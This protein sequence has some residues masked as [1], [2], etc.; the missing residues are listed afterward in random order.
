[1]S[2]NKKEQ[3]ISTSIVVLLGATIMLHSFSLLS[4]KYATL[5]SGLL[6]LGLIAC[7]LCISALRA[8]LW[9]RLLAMRELSYLYP[10]TALVQLVIPFYAVTLFGE[11]VTSG[12]LLGLGFIVAGS[13]TMA[14]D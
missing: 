10:Y 1:M 11:S 12:N 3:P 9:Q 7:A 5:N 4:L 6:A 2:V 14:Q 13:F 8:F